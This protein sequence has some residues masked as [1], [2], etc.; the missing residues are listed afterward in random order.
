MLVK[1]KQQSYGQ[2]MAIMSHPKY[3]LCV[4]RT[5]VGKPDVDCYG[6]AGYIQVEVEWEVNDLML[7]AEI[8]KE[9]SLSEEWRDQIV[10]LENR[11]G[12]GK[13]C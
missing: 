9:I 10:T 4:M 11:L 7:F 13:R 6:M 2:V 12:F 3:H 1:E 8:R 5:N